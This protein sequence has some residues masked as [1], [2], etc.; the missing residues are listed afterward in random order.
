MSKHCCR[1]YARTTRSKLTQLRRDSQFFGM[2]EK[3]LATK[4]DAALMEKDA[5]RE[6]KNRSLGYA[7]EAYVRKNKV[8]ISVQD[9]LLAF[10]RAVSSASFWTRLKYFLTCE[11]KGVGL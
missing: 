11:F 1:R 5:L 2:T 4:L 8:L 10:R 3:S 9:E 7:D 6:L